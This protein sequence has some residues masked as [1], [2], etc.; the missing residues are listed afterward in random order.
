MQIIH[1]KNSQSIKEQIKRQLKMQIEKGELQ[2]GK[3]TPSVR[4]LAAI[5]NVNRNTVASAYK[6]LTSEGILETVV[7]TGTFVRIKQPSGSKQSLYQIM[8]KAVKEAFSLGYD[9]QDITECFYNCISSLPAS[10]RD[11]TVMVVECN[12]PLLDYFCDELAAQC[13]VRI[14]GVLIDELE[15]NPLA[16]T[17]QLADIDLVV[18]GFNH[19]EELIT[20][21]PALEKKLL[22]CI[23]Q[24]DLQILN[25]ITQLPVGA[26]VGYVCVNQR[27]AKTFF[28]SS[29][30][31]G[32][33]ELKRIV[34]GINNTEN[35][36]SLLQDCT[37]I[38]VTNFAYEQVAA[39]IRP[40]Q[41]LVRVDIT[42]DPGSVNLIKERIG[43]IAKKY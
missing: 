37:T 42:L 18:C 12:Q 43:R 16:F 23:L 39:Q 32:H 11:V 40:G 33:K 21:I 19:V 7:G 3:P 6:E 41:E 9:P 14:K 27:S 26:A 17:A 13:Q 10:Y 4:D 2:A 38:F 15:E 31:S 22:G 35:L 30:F 28:N 24:T 25:K 8:E 1:N 5:L 20:A 29:Y 36:H 34:A